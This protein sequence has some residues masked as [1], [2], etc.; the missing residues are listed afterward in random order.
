MEKFKTKTEDKMITQT[1][2]IQIIQNK[3]ILGNEHFNYNK[4]MNICYVFDHGAVR[5]AGVSICSVCENNK[6]HNII[7]HALCSDLEPDDVLKLRQ[8]ANKYK[9]TII[10]YFINKNAEILRNITLGTFPVTIWYRIFLPYIINCKRIL[11]LDSDIINLKSLNELFKID[12]I[13][14][15]L[16]AVPDL[17]KTQ[18]DRKS[19]LKLQS[20]I[21]FNSGVLMINTPKW[22]QNDIS[23]KILLTAKNY[24]NQLTLPDQDA[25]NIVFEKENSI[26]FLNKKYNRVALWKEKNIKEKLDDTVLLHFVQTKPWQEAWLYEKRPYI[27][28]LYAQYEAL[29]PWKGTPLEKKANLSYHDK[30]KR[31]EFM[32]KKGNIL[33]SLYWYK[34]YLKNKII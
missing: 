17:E 19:A 22:Q 29:S 5:G 9:I 28:N 13:N 12:M 2:I 23:N 15:C 4:S 10:L 34:E 16:L 27:E 14:Y 33:K 31:A 25:L 3:I 7:F 1:S 6:E 21:Y 8:I 20:N 11:Y 30:R 26:F 18:K 32:L 24:G